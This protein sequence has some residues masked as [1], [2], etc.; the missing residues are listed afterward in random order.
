MN[1]QSGMPIVPKQGLWE[2]L[3]S[4]VLAV[5]KSIDG[6]GPESEI[7]ARLHNLEERVSRLEQVK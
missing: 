4:T 5:A 2:S 3:R 1:D 6:D 7:I